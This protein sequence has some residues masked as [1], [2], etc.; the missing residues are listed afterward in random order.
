MDDTAVEI[1]LSSEKGKGI[2]NSL[3]L[4]HDEYFRLEARASQQLQKG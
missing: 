3:S 4:I 2:K 1:L